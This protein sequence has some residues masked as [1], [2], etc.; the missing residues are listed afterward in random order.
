MKTRNTVLS[1]LFIAFGVILPMFFHQLNMGGPGFL[2]MHIPVLIGA[3]LLGPF[4]GLLIGFVTPLL[5]SIL[6]GMPPAFPMLP[7]MFFELGVY[8][9]VAGYLYKNLKLNIY[10]SLIISMIVGRI[11]AGVVVFFLGEFFNFQGP[12]PV[13]YVSGAVITG[14]IGIVIQL[15][16]VPVIVKLIERGT[17]LK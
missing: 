13:A 15:V 10:I 1:G 3:F 5:S 6:T 17:N 4:S 11:V 12:G 14:V 16:A 8:G 2:P 9:L 7:I